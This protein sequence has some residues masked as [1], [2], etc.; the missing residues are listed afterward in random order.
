MSTRS[1]GRREFTLESALAVL[2]AAVITIA[3]EACG[4]SSSPTGPSAQPPASGDREGVVSANHGH[5]AIIASAQLVAADAISLNIQGAAT[6]NHVVTLT[7]T[8]VAAIAGDQRISTDS[9]NDQSHSH[10][11]TFN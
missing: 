8:Q 6:H 2:G 5:R 11:V 1:L 4:G 3:G 7:A 10:R 9:T